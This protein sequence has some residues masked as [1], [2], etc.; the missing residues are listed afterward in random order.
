MMDRFQREDIV[1]LDADAVVR[2]Y[3]KLFSEID[4]D[5]ACHFRDWKHGRNELLSGTLFIKNNDKARRVI[6]D[7]IKINDQNP[8]TWEQRNLARA[9]RRYDFDLKI[10]RLPIEYCFIFDDERK[11]SVKPIIEHFQASRKYRREI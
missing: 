9:I 7:W 4:C 11:G 1:W 8:K 3:P 2:S 6:R 10:Y 5:L